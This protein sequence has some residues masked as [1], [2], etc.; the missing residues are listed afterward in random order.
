MDKTSA[1]L[2]FL[3]TILPLITFVDCSSAIN[4]TN[5]LTEV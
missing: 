5:D 3:E 1:T 4:Y 2:D